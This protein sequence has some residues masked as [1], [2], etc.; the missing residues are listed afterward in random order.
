MTRGAPVYLVC[1][2]HGRV[3]TST[4]A[5]LLADYHR[6]EK[7]PFTVFDTDP[8]ERVLAGFFPG[9]STVADLSLTRGQIALFDRLLL[10]GPE[11]RIVDIW[12]R[13]YRQF[14]TQALDIGFFEEAARVGLAPIVL[15]V[16]D[17]SWSS[18]E[19][20]SRILQT[21][22]GMPLIVVAD[23]G[24][25]PLGDAALD[26]LS[27]FPSERNFQISDLDPIVRRQIEQPGFS[28]SRFFLAPPSGM[29]LVIRADLLAWL[30][31]IFAQFQ[32]YELR[33]ALEGTRYLL[34]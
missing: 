1:S 5:R 12:S 4:T 21:W 32:S 29:S 28:L 10:Q 27:S 16:T 25:A 2:P 33:S 22:P 8:H 24:A 26:H 11:A 7:R 6:I 34:K 31:R 20:A 30:R 3:G 23:E 18:V 15:F 17:G 14:F 13:A 9:E 19:A